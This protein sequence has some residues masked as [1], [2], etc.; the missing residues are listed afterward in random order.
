MIRVR[1]GLL[2]QV[3]EKGWVA[4]GKGSEMLFL[5]LS[6]P[7]TGCFLRTYFSAFAG[8][9]GNFYFKVHSVS[10]ELKF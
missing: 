4:K 10:L 6:H 5:E 3:Y 2:G 8:S 1:L 7:A 9:N